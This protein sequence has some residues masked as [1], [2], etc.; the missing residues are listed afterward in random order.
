MLGKKKL[1]QSLFYDKFIY[2]KE[3]FLFRITIQRPYWFLPLG[4]KNPLGK[5]VLTYPVTVDKEKI[6][7]LNS[8][9]PSAFTDTL[10]TSLKW[11]E[12]KA[13]SAGAKSHLL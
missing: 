7:V 13:A 3:I 11:M 10:F 1:T 6:E 9:F 5:Y 12:L 2:L 8:L 4:K